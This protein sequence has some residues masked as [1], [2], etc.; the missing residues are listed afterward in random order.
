MRVPL[1]ATRVGPVASMRS[2]EKAV[3]KNANFSARV[4]EEM[5]TGR[6]V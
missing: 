6:Y 3:W 4:N 5:T 1:A 2:V